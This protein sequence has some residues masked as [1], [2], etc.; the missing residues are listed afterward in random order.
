MVV[1]GFFAQCALHSQQFVVSTRPDCQTNAPKRLKATKMH[2]L[3]IQKSNL[4]N[5]DRHR[6]LTMIAK[7]RT[8]NQRTTVLGECPDN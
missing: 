7:K 6:T 4:N 5:K 3:E 2:N 8:N 1:T